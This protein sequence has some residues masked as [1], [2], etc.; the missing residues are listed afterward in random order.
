MLI[1]IHIPKTGGITM[2]QVLARQFGRQAA[3]GTHWGPQMPTPGSRPLGIHV[4]LKLK[5]HGTWFP[6]LP[7]VA[8]FR[9]SQMPTPRQDR[10]RAIK[11]HMGFGLGRYLS[12]PSDYVTLLRDPVDRVLSHYYYTVDWQNR[13]SDTSLYEHL[14]GLIEGN[15]QTRMLAAPYDDGGG[16]LPPEQLLERAKRHLQACVVVGLTERFDETLLMLRQAVGW[17]WPFYVRANVNRSRPPGRAVPEEVRQRIANDNALD[18]ALYQY[19]VELFAEQ[20]GR[21]GPSLE[22]DLQ[23]FRR[24]NVARQRRYRIRKTPRR[25]FKKVH[26]LAWPLLEPAYRAL[27]DWGGL[28][29]MIPA[30]LKP[31][32]VASQALGVSG[33]RLYMG[34]RLVGRYR[35][36]EHCWEI[37]RPFHLFV[38]VAELPD[39]GEDEAMA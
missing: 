18:A 2:N 37:Q 12:A 36:M 3:W 25:T 11:G 33:L 27:S 22:G 4:G 35:M 15:L 17:Q 28:R 21:Y 13:P 1:F 10:I 9:F 23:H 8:A 31:Q 20:V 26:R 6:E 32:V 24:L 5:P 38:D 16:E 39:P 30:R 7:Q 14:S 29:R 19:A 34:E